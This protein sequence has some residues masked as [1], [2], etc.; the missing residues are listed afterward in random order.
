MSTP[1][2]KKETT[3]PEVHVPESVKGEAKARVTEA[4]EV[5][6]PIQLSISPDAEEVEVK[7][8]LHLKVNRKTTPEE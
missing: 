7:I 2:I 5:D 8:K 3:S 4:H 6:V 1:E